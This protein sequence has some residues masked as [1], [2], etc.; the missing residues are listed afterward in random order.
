MWI[1]HL[2]FLDSNNA[3]P[4]GSVNG[5]VNSIVD[6]EERKWAAFESLQWSGQIVYSIISG[7]GARKNPARSLKRC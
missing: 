7:S 4:S 6:V 5:S 1:R 2:E 3:F